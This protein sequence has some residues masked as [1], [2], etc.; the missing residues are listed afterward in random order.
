MA[1]ENI[2][3]FDVALLLFSFYLAHR[4][5]KVRKQFIFLIIL[6][7]IWLLIKVLKVILGKVMSPEDLGIKGIIIISFMD[8][9]WLK[10]L[11][12]PLSFIYSFKTEKY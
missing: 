10:Y 12:A 8:T 3:I 11:V 4:R 7:G 2:Y 6:L 1:I 9:F 5:H